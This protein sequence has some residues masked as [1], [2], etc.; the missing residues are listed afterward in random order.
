MR[1]VAPIGARAFDLPSYNHNMNIVSACGFLI[2]NLAACGFSPDQLETPDDA[3]PPDATPID[4]TQPDAGD[5]G[6]NLCPCWLAAELANAR[7]RFR[8]RGR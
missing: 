3:S 5:A 1:G 2:A 4:A 6:G 8:S 7:V